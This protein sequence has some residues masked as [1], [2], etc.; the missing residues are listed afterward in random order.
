[1]QRLVRVISKKHI[2]DSSKKGKKES[3]DSKKSLLFL[4]IALIVRAV[5]DSHIFYT[6]L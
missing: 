6:F 3:R 2:T 4:F 5:K 1:M